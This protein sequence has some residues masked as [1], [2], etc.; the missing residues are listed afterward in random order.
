MIEAAHEVGRED[1][2]ILDPQF[3]ALL[4]H[5]AVELAFHFHHRALAVGRGE[6]GD[7]RGRIAAER[8][9]QV[10]DEGIDDGRGVESELQR[11]ALGFHVAQARREGAA[12]LFDDDGLLLVERSLD[13]GAGD[14]FHFL[15]D[16]GIQLFAQDAE[17]VGLDDLA[18]DEIGVEDRGV[19]R[20][21]QQREQQCADANAGG[22]HGAESANRIHGAWGMPRARGFAANDGSPA[23]SGNPERPTSNGREVK[24]GAWRTGGKP[25]ARRTM[26]GRAP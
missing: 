2:R 16:L 14:L 12:D 22:Q 7:L 11:G 6:L 26:L 20:V 23:T 8:R 25:G 3:R 21:A 19:D 4:R 9:A 15:A 17:D 10:R 18:G 1:R 24:A 13:R 5:Q